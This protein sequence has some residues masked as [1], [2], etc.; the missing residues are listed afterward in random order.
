MLKPCVCRPCSVYK[1]ICVWFKRGHFSVILMLHLNIVCYRITDNMFLCGPGT[2]FNQ[3][4]RTCQA[5]DLVDCSL[6]ASLYYLNSHFQLPSPGNGDIYV[7]IQ[8]TMCWCSWLTDLNV[9][10]QT[11]NFKHLSLSVYLMI[12][13]ILSKYQQKFKYSDVSLQSCRLNCILFCVDLLCGSHESS[14]FIVLDD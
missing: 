3:Q 6:S 14:H 7:Y 5:R 10:G 8:D 9:Q 13:L 1:F 2:R 11:V 4:S 12:C